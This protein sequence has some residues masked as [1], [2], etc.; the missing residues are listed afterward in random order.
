MNIL[1]QLNPAR[2]VCFSGHRPER[3]PRRGKPDAPEMQTLAAAL[4]HEIEYAIRRGLD[5][6]LN[7][8]MAGWDVLSAEQVLALKDQYPHIRLV[9]LAP[10]AVGFF[11]CEKCW[12]DD[13]IKRAKE[14]CRQSDIGVSL[15]ERYRAGIY[16]ERNHILV[17]HSAE[18][19][20]YWDGDKGGTQFT[21]Q[22]A[23]SRGQAVNNLFSPV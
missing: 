2:S 16:Y 11:S 9:T 3:L 1:E 15:A 19:I 17:D 23:K 22:Y 21:V 18:L 5:T 14:V 13:W 7:G 8:L 4:R 12:T 6:F 20:C 10:Y